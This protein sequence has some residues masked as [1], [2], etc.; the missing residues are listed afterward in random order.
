[1]RALRP[2][3]LVHISRMLCE[4]AEVAAIAPV[5]GWDDGSLLRLHAG[6]VLILYSLD[7]DANL[8][9]HHVVDSSARAQ[10]TG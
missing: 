10:G 7:P 2:A 6:Q 9:V 4:I 1:M 3:M 5:S 8:I